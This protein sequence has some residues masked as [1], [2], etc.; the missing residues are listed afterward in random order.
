MAQDFGK[1][2]MTAITIDDTGSLSI[3]L[4]IRQQLG[5]TIAQSLNLEIV[6]GCIILQPIVQETALVVETPPRDN[7]DTSIEDLRAEGQHLAIDRKSF[8]KLPIEERNRILEQQAEA[9]LPHYQQN[10]SEWQEWLD[11]DISETYVS[12]NKIRLARYHKSDR[13]NY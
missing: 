10:Q 3:P 5:I 9:A 7:L 8:L 1:F 13:C 2:L 4:E 12:S 6:N 11:L